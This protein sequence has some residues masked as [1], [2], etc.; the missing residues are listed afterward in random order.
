MYFDFE[1]Y[2]PDYSPVGRALT[3]LE[4]VLL[5]IIFHLVAVIFILLSPKYFPN[6]FAPPEIKPLVV[7]QPKERTQFVFVQPNNDPPAPKPPPRAELSDIDRQAQAPKRAERPT[8]PLPM[9]RGNSPDRTIQDL[10]Q[11]QA[12]RGQ[13]PT[14][15][16]AAGQMAR[17]QPPTADTTTP[18]VSESTS[19]L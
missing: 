18:P 4:V 3:R 19:A 15:D 7:Q 8:N 6:L 14:P 10:Q 9:S 16:P 11:K 17:N 5:T 12:A 2:R 13:G 1:D